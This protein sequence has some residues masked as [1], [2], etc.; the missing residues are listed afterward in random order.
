MYT[1]WEDQALAKQ[2]NHYLESKPDATKAEI[3]RQF[4]TTPYR[5]KILIKEGLISFQESVIPFY[6]YRWKGHNKNAVKIPDT[7]KWYTDRYKDGNK[8]I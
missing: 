6:K 1:L 3:E 7:I 5:L 8:T 4:H 2:I